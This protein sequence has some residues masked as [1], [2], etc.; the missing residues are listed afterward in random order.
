MACVVREYADV[1][2]GQIRR[3]LANREVLLAQIVGILHSPLKSQF[4]E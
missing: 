4:V 2:V 3:G 1:M